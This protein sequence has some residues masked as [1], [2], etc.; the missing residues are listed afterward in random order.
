MLVQALT[1]VRMEMLKNHKFL[2]Q[3]NFITLSCDWRE[4]GSHAH[5]QHFQ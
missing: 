1:E 4:D 5:D 2:L 3:L